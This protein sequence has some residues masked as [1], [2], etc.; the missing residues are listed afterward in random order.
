MLKAIIIEDNLDLS[1]LLEKITSRFGYDVECVKQA[2]TYE[3]KINWNEYDLILLDAG[4]SEINEEE[5]KKM[6]SSK[7]KF[8]LM[9]VFKEDLIGQLTQA[10][11]YDYF[12]QKPF[13][14][15]TV[16][17]ILTRS[18]ESDSRVKYPHLLTINDN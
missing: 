1:R 4:I 2:I 15:D 18:K 11:T 9:S 12:L 6:W 16:K 7:A 8:C 17:R 14:L 13:S 5:V 10:I 3:K